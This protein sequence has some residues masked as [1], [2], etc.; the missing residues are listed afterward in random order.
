MSP[1]LLFSFLPKFLLKNSN[2]VSDEVKRGYRCNH[3]EASLAR[4]ECEW[5]LLS[6]GSRE[7]ACLSTEV[8]SDL[9]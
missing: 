7:R 6:P 8:N 3:M 2:L 5:Q 9:G 1:F 4:P